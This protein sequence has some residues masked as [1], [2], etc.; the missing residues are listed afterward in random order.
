MPVKTQE[1]RVYPPIKSVHCGCQ[2]EVFWCF[3]TFCGEIWGT[4]TLAQADF[5]K[6]WALVFCAIF[7]PL[8]YRDQQRSS[9]NEGAH[10]HKTSIVWWWLYHLV[11]HDIFV[12]DS[13]VRI[14][15]A[16]N[17]IKWRLNRSSCR[18]RG[19]CVIDT[20]RLCPGVLF[21]SGMYDISSMMM[22]MAF[23]WWIS[24]IARGT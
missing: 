21:K 10:A 2:S 22:K 13:L 4:L 19:D 5:F 15:K 23:L 12:I 1:E 8:G 3:P 20:K 16:R 6:H 7:P 24:D 11:K 17:T 14:R 18:N 9:T